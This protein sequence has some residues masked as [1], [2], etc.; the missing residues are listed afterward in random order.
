MLPINELHAHAIEYKLR[1]D[2]ADRHSSLENIPLR[3][4]R[5]RRPTTPSI[6]RAT[7]YALATLSAIAGGRP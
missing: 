2:E 5:R 7:R 6:V 3:A 4:P 1:I